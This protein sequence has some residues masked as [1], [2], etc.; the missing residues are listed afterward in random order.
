MQNAASVFLT[1]VLIAITSAIVGSIIVLKLRWRG[2][3]TTHSIGCQT[4]SIDSFLREFH[5]RRGHIK[6]SADERCNDPPKSVQGGH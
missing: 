5:H 4:A 1:R 6:T 2:S 3:K